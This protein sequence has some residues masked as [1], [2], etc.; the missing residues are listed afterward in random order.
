MYEHVN[1]TCAVFSLG[2]FYALFITFQSIN[3]KF[4]NLTIYLAVL[5][6]L[7]TVRSYAH[8]PPT[9]KKE[10]IARLPKNKNT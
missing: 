9:P 1:F 2:S 6:H 5:I 3:G 10:L 7:F 4:S 8:P